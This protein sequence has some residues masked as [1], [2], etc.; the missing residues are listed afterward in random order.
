MPVKTATPLFFDDLRQ[1]A[2]ALLEENHVPPQRYGT[3]FHLTLPFSDVRELPPSRYIRKEVHTRVLE[4]L[5]EENQQQ[6]LKTITNP[7]PYLLWM[8]SHADQLPVQIINV[9]P[10]QKVDAAVSGPELLWIFL[11]EGSQLTLE[12]TVTGNEIGINRV[13]V[14]QKTDS[15]F[16]YWGLRANNSF[17]TDQMRVQLEGAY[18]SVQVRHLTF[19]YAKQQSD[20]EVAA[21]HQAPQTESNLLVRTAA[22]DKHVSIYR[23]LIDIAETAKG[24]KGY[25]S[26]NALLLSRKAVVDNLPELAIRTNDVQ[27]SHGVNTTHIDDAALFYI[28]SR[29][30]SREAA[31]QLAITGFYH[32]KMDIPHSLSSSL[33]SILD[34]QAQASHV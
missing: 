27:C 25:Q 24:S 26:G 22:A 10:G 6:I 4:D 15:H 30:L 29:G 34:A 19:G 33:A 23:G 12:Q 20:M 32:D 7:D 14:W 13:F 17:L 21:Y 5:S 28:R 16:T 1:K 8:V 9:S 18:A 11:E 2:T 3:A 31:R